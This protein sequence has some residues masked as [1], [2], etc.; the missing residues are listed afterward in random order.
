VFQKAEDPKFQD[1]RHMKVV[2]LSA[3]RTGHLYPPEVSL[4]VIS[5]SG[6][7]DPRAIMRA[8]GLCQRKIPRTPTGIEP[9]TSKVVAQCLNQ[10]RHS[11]PPHKTQR[12]TNT[13]RTWYALHM[14]QSHLH[15]KHSFQTQSFHAR[16]SELSTSIKTAERWCS[17]LYTL[18]RMFTFV[19]RL[20]RLD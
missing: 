3:L 20:F 10:I 5:V 4:I 15:T 8:E 7:V 1:N 11:L 14:N 17:S 12:G 9:A 16:Q 2:R 18:P 19:S 13:K 6:W